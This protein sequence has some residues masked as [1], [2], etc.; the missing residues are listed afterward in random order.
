LSS[1]TTTEDEND[2]KM[3]DRGCE[4][5]ELVCIK[6]NDSTVAIFHFCYDGCKHLKTEIG[7]TCKYFKCQ[8]KTCEVRYYVTTTLAS[9]TITTYFPKSHNHY[10]PEKPR[11]RI[12]VKEKALSH[13]SISATPSVV[14]KQF[15]N[16]APLPLFSADAPSLS[17]LKNWKY[18]KSMK[19]MPS[20]I[21]AFFFLKYLGFLMIKN[22]RR[23]LQ[24]HKKT[25]CFYE[26]VCPS[27]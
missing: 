24:H 2:N 7:V 25:P 16:D 10:P 17:Q 14:H 27:L 23:I 12:S 4:N 15:V 3:S 9:K 22:R 18:R 6:N 20:G 21:I 19:D 1:D 11:T 13:F 26:V 8:E 5:K